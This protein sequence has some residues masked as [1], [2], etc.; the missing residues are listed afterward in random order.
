MLFSVTRRQCDDR[1]VTLSRAGEID[2][3]TAGALRAAIQDTLHTPHPIDVVVDLGR[4]TFLDC[5]GI[6]A[7]VAGRNTAVR[8]GRGYTVV[9]PQPPVRRVLDIAGV[10]A[11]LT[12]CP[13]PASR[14]GQPVRSTRSGD[15]R[16][17]RPVAAGPPATADACASRKNTSR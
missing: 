3:R 5:A 6:G 10:H 15:R 13:D 14:T 9:N 1:V 12:G 8:R 2:L 16:H 4:V 11:A 7:L 17:D